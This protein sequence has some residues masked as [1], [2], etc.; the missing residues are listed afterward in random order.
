MSKESDIFKIVEY[1]IIQSPD[2]LQKYCHESPIPAIKNQASIDSVT[3]TTAKAELPASRQGSGNRW[4][5][6]TQGCVFLAFRW[7]GSLGSAPGLQ[8]CF[9]RSRHPAA[10]GSCST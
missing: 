10:E 5:A 9:L 8:A 4:T 2:I 6:A 7:E 3:L 1:S